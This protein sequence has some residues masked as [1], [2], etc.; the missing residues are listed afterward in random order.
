MPGEKGKLWSP[1][2][3]LYEF[4]GLGQV[5]YL[6]GVCVSLFVHRDNYSSYLIGSWWD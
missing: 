5:P 1:A 6:L 2:S 3:A 4:D